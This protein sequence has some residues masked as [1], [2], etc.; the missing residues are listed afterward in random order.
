MAYEFKRAA[1]VSGDPEIIGNELRKLMDAHGGS[2]T[3]TDI[4]AAARKKG[5]PLH[6]FFEWDDTVA[7][8]QYRLVQARFL[9]RI[10]VNI[11]DSENRPMVRA[12][13]HVDPNLQ[14]SRYM[15]IESALEHADTRAQ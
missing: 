9:L 4:V 10:I 11:D 3:P 8:E 6:E 14:S 13:V 2:V 1:R 7:A 5:S 15:Q 12:F